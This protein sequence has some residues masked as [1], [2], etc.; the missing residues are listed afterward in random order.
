[1]NA[2][3]PAPTRPVF[4]SFPDLAALVASKTFRGKG[5]LCVALVVTQHA[6]ERGLPLDPESLLTE[7]GGQVLGLGRSAVQAILERHGISRVLAHEGGRTSRGS[8]DNMR[9]YVAT[10]NA[11]SLAGELDLDEVEGFWIERVRDFFAAKPFK[12]RLDQARGL[13]ALV[14]DLLRQAEERQKATPGVQYCGAVLQHLLGAALELAA[15]DLDFEHHCSATADA[16][17]SRVGDFQLGDL[18]LHATTAP[19][20]AL[21]RKCRDNLDAGLKPA[22][23]TL[24]RGL[25]LA[26]GLARNAGLETRVDCLDIEQYLTV[27]LY[28]QSRFSG[29]SRRDALEALVERYNRIVDAVETDPSLR[30]ELQG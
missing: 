4:P 30:V 11:L 9:A 28:S 16:S 21:M 22:L 20:E 29:Q 6:R 18:V 24:P 27:T 3:A 12:L 5:P 13:R 10:L 7:R 26:E 23:V 19:S 17:S 8:I 2:D 1:M 14:A 15:P 25:A